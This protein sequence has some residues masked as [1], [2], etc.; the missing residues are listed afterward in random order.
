M[1]PVIQ[2]IANRVAKDDADTV[3]LNRQIGYRGQELADF[4]RAGYALGHTATIDGP[5]FITFVDTLTR[6][7][8]N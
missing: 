8:E 7:V 6:D 1:S 4:A 2:I 3:T 5:D